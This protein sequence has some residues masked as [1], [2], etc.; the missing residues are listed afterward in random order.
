[1]DDS[2][3]REQMNI[4]LREQEKAEKTELER[5]TLDALKQGELKG[6]I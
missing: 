5:L 4:I 1:M 3:Y 2:S 6:C